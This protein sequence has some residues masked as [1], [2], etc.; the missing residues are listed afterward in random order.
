MPSWYV[1][2]ALQGSMSHFPD[3]Q[4]ANRLLQRV[5][6]GR[7]ELSDAFFEKKL[8]AA[9]RHLDNWR[10]VAD[11]G[12]SPD[13][14]VELG[15]GW[16]PVVPVAMAL[17]GVGRVISV[18]L[19]PLFQDEQIIETLEAFRSHIDRHPQAFEPAAASRV[20]LALAM[21]PGDG[22][23]RLDSLGVSSLVADASKLAMGSAS[24]D[25]V[26]SNNTLEH[27]PADA[28]ASILSEFRRV[29]RPGGASSHLID[30][31]DHYAGFDSSLTPYHF[32]RFSQRRW[33]L[34]NNSLQ[35]QNRLRHSQYLD[36]F[37]R[38]GW[39]LTAE[40][41]TRDT[42]LL[43][44]ESV[45]ADF[46]HFAPEDLAVHTAWTVHRPGRSS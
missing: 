32:L 21:S 43:A 34:F 14:V 13:V 27:I 9:Q 6:T 22:R 7:L 33:E 23:Q 26:T 11:S 45:H 31:A 44:S 30:L 10:R 29:I 46:S 39:F 17:S 38:S 19:Q 15:T 40:D 42:A 12:G 1:K 3:P 5:V 36:I 35:Y 18:D 41:V 4:R 37:E 28:L 20:A 16:H 2:A 24:V 8:V 25:L